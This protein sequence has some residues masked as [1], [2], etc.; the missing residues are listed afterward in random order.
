MRL[1]LVAECTVTTTRC[2]PRSP[3]YIASC[4]N[5]QGMRR[6][7]LQGKKPHMWLVGDAVAHCCG[8]PAAFAAWFAVGFPGAEVARRSPQA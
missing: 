5:E 1:K 4:C 2:A 3:D 8:L 7:A 6:E